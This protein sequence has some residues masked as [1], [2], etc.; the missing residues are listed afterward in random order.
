MAD[1]R[2]EREKLAS[3]WGALKSERE[4]WMSVYQD[5]TDNLLPYSGRYFVQDRNRGE[6]RT[7]AIYDRTATGD[8]RILCA[9]LM[10]GMSSPARDRKSTRLN[11]SHLKLSRMPSSA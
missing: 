6:R 9:G 7:G 2:T 11:S 4:S 5:V 8:L 10:A 3:R 1:T